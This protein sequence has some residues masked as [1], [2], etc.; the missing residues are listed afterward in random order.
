MSPAQKERTM[1]GIDKDKECPLC[2]GTGKVLVETKRLIGATYPENDQWKGD[3]HF[4]PC[5][6]CK[7]TRKEGENDRTGTDKRKGFIG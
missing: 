5:P 3:E 1:E 7:P 2:N 4:A 6:L